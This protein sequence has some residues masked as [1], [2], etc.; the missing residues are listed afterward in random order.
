MGCDQYAVDQVCMLWLSFTAMTTASARL[1]VFKVK[2]GSYLKVHLPLVTSLHPP[3]T[4]VAV[5]FLILLNTFI[6][7]H[8]TNNV[9]E[10]MCIV[11]H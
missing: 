4:P 3:T 11:M 2:R 1:C 9:L 6:F 10:T 8:N 7:S 5:I